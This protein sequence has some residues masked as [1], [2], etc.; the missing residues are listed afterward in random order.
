MDLEQEFKQLTI[1][2]NPMGGEEPYE[3]LHVLSVD[4][5]VINLAIT[6]SKIDRE[7]NF[8]EVIW[9][10]LINITEF[11]HRHVSKEN[12]RLHH[13]R[14]FSDWLDHVYQDNQNFFQDVDF[15]IIER[16]PPMGFVAVEQLIFN[17]YRDKST[18]INPKNVHTFLNMS[19]LD[20]QG[21]KD[22]SE[23]LAMPLVTDPDL[24]EQIAMYHRQHDICDS[25]CM[26]LYWL[27]KKR[28]EL[29]KQKLLER[30]NKT[31]IDTININDW[32]D[33]RR[34]LPTR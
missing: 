4:I 33:Q 7:F 5:G 23:K 6:V 20:Y 28:K 13:S 2:E 25:L 10:D 34:Y 21:R 30:V 9:L 1:D 26:L 22:R 14:T 11:N 15:I 19:N 12:C 29:N 17:K 32:L 27:E 31:V 16:Q 18:L 8:I 24:R 3:F